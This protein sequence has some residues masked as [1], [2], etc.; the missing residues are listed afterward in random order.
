MAGDKDLR[1][2]DPHDDPLYSMLVKHAQDQIHA[3]QTIYKNKLTSL[4]TVR[5]RIEQFLILL[6]TNEE[7]QAKVIAT[8]KALQI[9]SDILTDL[10]IAVSN[11]REKKDLVSNKLTDLTKIKDVSVE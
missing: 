2:R 8:G 3:E 10:F 7:L 1:I 5:R 11:I 4:M 6:R 9:K